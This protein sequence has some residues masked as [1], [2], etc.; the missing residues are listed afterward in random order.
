MSH[1]L[2]PPL[3]V[4]TSVVYAPSIAKQ[5]RTGLGSGRARALAY[6]ARLN[7][8][9]KA[10]APLFRAT[11]VKRPPVLTERGSK[12]IT[13]ARAMRGAGNT[14]SY[15]AQTSLQSYPTEYEISG[16]Y[17]DLVGVFTF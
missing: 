4:N 2:T 15:S 13:I 8:A 14:S 12:D 11:H 17:A 10:N 5:A 1:T 9:L 16:A 3:V 7:L 6:E